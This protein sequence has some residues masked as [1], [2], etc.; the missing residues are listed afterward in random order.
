MCIQ[1]SW[2]SENDTSQI[3]LEDYKCIAQG[4]SFS[5]KG[6]LI[7]YLNKQY[8]YIPKIKLNKYNTWEGQF[9]QVKKRKTLSKPINI[10]NIYRPRKQNPTRLSNNHGTLIDNFF[11]KLMEAT[12][13]T[14][15]GVLRKKLSDY[16]PYFIILNNVKI[17]DHPPI[18]LKINK[19]DKES[20]QNFH[21]E[22]LTSNELN[23]LNKNFTEDPNTTYNILHNAIQSAKH[24]HMPHRFAKFSKYKHKK[25]KWI[26][27]YITKSIHYRDNLYK[28]TQNDGSQFGTIHSTKYLTL[29]H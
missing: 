17:R 14:T 15:S 13:D 18:Y 12:L 4:K 11:C 16:Q 8:G 28:K 27:Y 10:R 22:I 5:S 6:G 3:K 9:I 23:S 1:E 24:R 29:Y 26:T 20:I 2:L 7:I 25:S 19:Q 21:N